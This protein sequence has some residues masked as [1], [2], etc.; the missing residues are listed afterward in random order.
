[1]STN[2]TTKPRA[3]IVVPTIREQHMRDFLVAW[4]DE[5]SDAHIIVVE[6]NP[7]RSFQIGASSNVTHYAWDKMPKESVSPLLDRR[8][9]GAIIDLRRRGID[10]VV[11]EVSPLPF[12]P[13]MPGVNGEVAHRLWQLQRALVR[14]RFAELGVP[15]VVWDPRRALAVTIE[16]IAAWPTARRLVR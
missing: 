8:A 1:M 10:V 5:F 9:I 16:E 4:K 7:T 6:D 11:V 12:A 14:D 3:T 15:V 13:A 2:G